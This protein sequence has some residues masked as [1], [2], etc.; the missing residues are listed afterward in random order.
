M[1]S[2]KECLQATFSVFQQPMGSQPLTARK[3]NGC[4][5]G[6]L[7]GSNRDRNMIKARLPEQSQKAATARWDKSK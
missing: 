5:G 4:I 1:M 6:K 7:G 3:A 2:N